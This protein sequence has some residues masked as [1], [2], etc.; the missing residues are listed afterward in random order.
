MEF[1]AV[2]AVEKEHLK[3]ADNN[4][5]LDISAGVKYQSSLSPLPWPKTRP[6]PLSL[7]LALLPL[8]IN[9]KQELGSFCFQPNHRL[10]PILAFCQ[11]NNC[12]LYQALSLRRHHIKLRN[13]Y[14]TD[15]QLNMG[16]NTQ[17]LQAAVAFEKTV[18]KYLDDNGVNYLTEDQ[19]REEWDLKIKQNGGFLPGP[20]PGTPD[21]RFDPPLPILDPDTG[22][23]RMIC[24]LEVKHF[25]GASS[26]P[27]DGKSACGRIPEISDRYTASFGVGALLFAYGV[28][29]ELLRKL[30]GTII[31]DESILD[32]EDTL[33]EMG[34]FCR[35]R[36]GQILP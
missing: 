10:P 16:T 21:F 20:H 25:Y 26:I 17:K 11:R 28:G 32:M 34:K 29:D 14:K 2:A 13:K 19:Q 8:L 24:W 1:V 18:S 31:L 5:S 35:R 4:T 9:H 33:R 6:L 23:V 15:Q 36:D 27:T 22:E 7:E 3:S 12:F 30:N